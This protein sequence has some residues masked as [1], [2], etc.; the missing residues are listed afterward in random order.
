MTNPGPT[1]IDGKPLTQLDLVRVPESQIEFADSAL[2]EIER[3]LLGEG[4]S[5][6]SSEE[7]AV[8]WAATATFLSGRLQG[9]DAH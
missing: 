2:R 8:V 4:R 5:D 7:E 6:P 3:R 1:N 9:T